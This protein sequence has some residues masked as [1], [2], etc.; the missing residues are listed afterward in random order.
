[1][2][3]QLTWNNIDLEY[4]GLLTHEILGKFEGKTR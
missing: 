1:M 4:V 3:V 2:D